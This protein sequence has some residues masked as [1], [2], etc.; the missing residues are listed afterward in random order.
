[1]HYGLPESITWFGQGIVFGIPVPVIISFIFVIFGAW[2][3]K[4]T[5]F[6]LH[7]KQLEEI[8]KPHGLLVYP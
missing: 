6:G 8:G 7:V 4:K 5:K 1:M 2:L 3:F